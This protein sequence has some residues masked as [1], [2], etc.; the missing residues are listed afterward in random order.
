MDCLGCLGYLGCL[1]WHRLAG[2]SRA[3]LA[4]GEGWGNM[5]RVGVD[6]ADMAGHG[7]HGLSR[8]RLGWNGCA[9]P[10]WAGMGRAGTGW[11]GVCSAGL[12]AWAWSSWRGLGG[13]LCWHRLP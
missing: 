11:S 2:L 9:G 8:V 5:A 1:G 12:V 10:V 3:G 7:L 4:W 6:W 13:G